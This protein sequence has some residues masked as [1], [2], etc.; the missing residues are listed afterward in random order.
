[1][2][3]LNNDSTTSHSVN[4]LHTSKH[5]LFQF[6]Y[7]LRI[8]A[9]LGIWGDRGTH[10]GSSFLFDTLV[11]SYCLPAWVERDSQPTAKT[12]ISSSSNKCVYSQTRTTLRNNQFIAT[13]NLRLSGGTFRLLN[14][15][16]M[17]FAVLKD[18]NCDT[19]LTI[20][21]PNLHDD[22]IQGDVVGAYL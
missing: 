3:E 15:K 7:A 13:T 16:F 5:S 21:T 17:R 11:S 1:M 18:G 9:D 20:R 14:I 10:W 6:P 8:G 19:P 12:I 2:R 22:E 4:C